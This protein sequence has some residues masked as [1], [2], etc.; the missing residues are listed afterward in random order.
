MRTSAK[1]LISLAIVFYLQIAC[2][3]IRSLQNKEVTTSLH[4]F[5]IIHPKQQDT[6]AAPP[7]DNLLLH[8]KR[9]FCKIVYTGNQLMNECKF[10]NAYF[11][12]KQAQEKYVKPMLW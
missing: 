3:Q 7:S 8:Q 1:F 10:D 6:S 11:F 2:K 12:Q 4:T 9:Y 5:A